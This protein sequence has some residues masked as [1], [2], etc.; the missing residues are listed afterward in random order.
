ME[1]LTG[2]T[3]SVCGCVHR[4][5]DHGDVIFI[6]L[7]DRKGLLQCVFDPDTALAGFPGDRIGGCFPSFQNLLLASGTGLEPKAGV[8]RS[9]AC[10]R[11]SDR[12][13]LSHSHN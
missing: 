10:G 9:M 13:R 1:A 6:D 12:V 4:R 7:R 8:S 3:V 2:E 11:L 5:R